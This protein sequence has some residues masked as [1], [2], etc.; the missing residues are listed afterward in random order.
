MLQRPPHVRTMRSSSMRKKLKLDSSFVTAPSAPASP[1]LPADANLGLGLNFDSISSIGP[2]VLP[3]SSSLAA[4]SIAIPA[5][6][7]PAIPT[8]SSFASHAGQTGSKK[9]K[10][11]TSSAD[12]PRP[13]TSSG[14]AGY[15]CNSLPLPSSTMMLPVSSASSGFTNTYTPISASSGAIDYG[16]LPNQSGQADDSTQ[17]E[18]STLMA[19]QT[20]PDL[21]ASRDYPIELAYYA[22]AAGQQRGGYL[23]Y[24]PAAVPAPSWYLQ[25][26]QAARSY[27]PLPK[28]AQSGQ[29]GQ[30]RQS[31]QTTRAAHSV[32]PSQALSAPGGAK[33]AFAPAPALYPSITGPVGQQMSYTSYSAASSPVQAIAAAAHSYPYPSSL[34]SHSPRHAYKHPQQPHQQAMMAVPGL[35]PV[36]L[37]SISQASAAAS[38]ARQPMPSHGQAFTNGYYSSFS[39]SGLPGVVQWT[40]QTS[41]V[42]GVFQP[43]PQPA[44]PAQWHF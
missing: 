23:A 32:S 41:R 29:S 43:Y 20:P 31:G 35:Q 34:P 42:S 14:T 25:P 7:S 13:S 27:A 40:T 24:Q 5:Y 10:L 19:K 1:T 39:N 8:A 3:G 6:S 28:H 16:F 11:S 22:L 26:Q 9:R 36:Q 30:S 37:Q 4:E 15:H 21:R 33:P 38:Q 17:T 2:A 12:Q 44:P 18:F